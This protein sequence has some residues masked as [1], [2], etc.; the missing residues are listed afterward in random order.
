MKIVSVNLGLPREVMWRGRSVLTGIFKEQV[1]ERVQLR[2]EVNFS[3]INH[4][5]LR[6]V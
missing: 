4:L 1:A 3:V 5:P 2:Y 6:F